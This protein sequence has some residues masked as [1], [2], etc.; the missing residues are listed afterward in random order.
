MNCHTLL[1]AVPKL[2]PHDWVHESVKNVMAGAWTRARLNALLVLQLLFLP[3]GGSRE[4]TRVLID[5]GC[6]LSGPSVFIKC[7]AFRFEYNFTLFFLAVFEQWQQIPN[8]FFLISLSVSPTFD[9]D[10]AN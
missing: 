4:K 3:P 7:Q 9:V 1:G 2:F 10:S 8:E 6:W 5:G